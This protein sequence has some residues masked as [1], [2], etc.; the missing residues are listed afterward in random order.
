MKYIIAV[1]AMVLGGSAYGQSC[2]GLQPAGSLDGGSFSLSGSGESRSRS[3][4]G[5]CPGGICRAPDQAEVD[6]NEARAIARS[7]EQNQTLEETSI[8]EQQVVVQQEQE[9][10]TNQEE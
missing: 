8:Q 10:T 6:R 5:G 7:E 1:V 3:N 9:A 4:G 2:W